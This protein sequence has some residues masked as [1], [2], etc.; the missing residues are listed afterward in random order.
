MAHASLASCVLVVISACALDHEA[1]AALAC[2]A[3]LAAAWAD[4]VAAVAAAFFALD[5][6]SVVCGRAA[7]RA[8]ATAAVRASAAARPR[9]EAAV[10]AARAACARATTTE[11]AAAAA[12]GPDIAM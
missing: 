2:D 12:R 9:S 7:A 6:F 11:R 10:R 5:C 8:L 4:L 1:T 3:P